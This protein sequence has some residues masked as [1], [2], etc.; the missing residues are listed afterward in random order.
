MDTVKMPR[1]G[2][3]ARNMVNCVTRRADSFIQLDQIDNYEF[4]KKGILEY[5]GKE[6][7]Q[8]NFEPIKR[9][10]SAKGMLYIETETM[11]VVKTEY[12]QFSKGQT[13]W[14]DKKWTEE[15]VKINDTWYL[16]HISYMEEWNNNPSASCNR[17]LTAFLAGSDKHAIPGPR[18]I[19]DF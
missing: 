18:R 8:I 1:F 19:P 3:H 14:T 10:A 2:A 13:Q 7:F 15:F 11:A 6:V 5:D 17:V 12:Y 9:K 4:T 16:S